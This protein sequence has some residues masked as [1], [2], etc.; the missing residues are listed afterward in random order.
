M[1]VKI[2]RKAKGEWSPPPEPIVDEPVCNFHDNDLR[3]PGFDNVATLQRCT[4]CDELFK[5]ASRQGNPRETCEVWRHKQ[6]K[7]KR[8]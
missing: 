8:R 4:E 7:D 6:I 3:R 2:I 5:D 1:P